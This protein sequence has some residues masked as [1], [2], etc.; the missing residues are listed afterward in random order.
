MRQLFSIEVD[1]DVTLQDDT[2]LL[3]PELREVYEKLGSEYIRYIIFTCDYKSPYRDLLPTKREEQVCDDVF[4]MPKK[5]VKELDS[6][7]LTTAKEKYK[8][9]QYDP[10]REQYLVYTE[11]IAEF[12]QW[13]RDMPITKDNAEMLGRVMKAQ[14]D[15]RESREELAQLI[16][17]KDEESKMMGGGE[18]SLLEEMFQ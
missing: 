1:G 9:L 10:L 18:A 6:I 4:G 7:L 2:F 11:K 13:L 3:I 14:T 5:K 12:N 16:L 8:Q 17:K 15:I